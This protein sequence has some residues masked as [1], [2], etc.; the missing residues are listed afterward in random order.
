MNWFKRYIHFKYDGYW[1]E[2]LDKILKV[3]PINKISILNQGREYMQLIENYKYDIIKNMIQNFLREF[4]RDR[5]VG[6][7]RIIFQPAFH[8]MNPC[9]KVRKKVPI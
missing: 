4:V 9:V 2:T 8:N 3:S 1:T 5:E 6:D 7:N